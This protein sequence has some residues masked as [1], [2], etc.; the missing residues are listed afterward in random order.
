MVYHYQIGSETFTSG[1]IRFLMGPMYRREEASRVVEPYNIG[2]VVRVAYDPANPRESVLEPGP[3]P[4]ALMNV[5]LVLLLVGVT[6][7]IYYE[8]RHPGRRVL[9]RSIPDHEV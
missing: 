5:L 3:P 9:L 8:V 1:R 6:G 4:G 2:R 7:Y